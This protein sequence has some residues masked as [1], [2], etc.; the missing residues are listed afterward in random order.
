MQD[1]QSLK[2]FADFAISDFYQSHFKPYLT[3]LIAESYD[4]LEVEPKDEFDC[5]KR[6]FALAGRKRA[7]KKILDK[8]ESANDQLNDILKKEFNKN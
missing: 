4:G 8:I 6:F 2:K 5:I 3:G 1:K 7:V